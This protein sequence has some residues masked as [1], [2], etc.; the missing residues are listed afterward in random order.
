[1]IYKYAL[2]QITVAII[3]SANL[4]N[5]L[6]I[7]FKFSYLEIYYTNKIQ[8]EEKV[9]FSCSFLIVSLFQEQINA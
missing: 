2:K 4:S 7:M 1:M 5:S 6:L 3:L 9:H 8:I